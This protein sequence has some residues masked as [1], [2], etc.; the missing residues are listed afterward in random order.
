MIN[1]CVLL[2]HGVQGTAVLEPLDLGIV[3][4]VREL[5]LKGGAILGV[6]DHG[7]RLSDG[8]LSAEDVDLERK[9]VIGQLG[10]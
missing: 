9:K 8:E 1:L 4:G 2:G 3:E 7:D 10:M 5:D 6:N